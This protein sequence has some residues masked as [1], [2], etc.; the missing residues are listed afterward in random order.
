M[1]PARSGH[2]SRPP[3]FW[4]AHGH[5]PPLVLING[6][7]ASGRAWPRAWLR[8]LERRFRVVTFDNRG[9]GFARYADTP[10]SIADLA[11]DAVK[12]MDA[13]DSPVAALFG[14]SM[15][16]MIA[17]ELALRHPERVTRL[18]LAASRPPNP[19]FRPPSLQSTLMMVRP[20]LP[21]ESLS[22]Y[23]EKLWSHSAAP[24]FAETHPEAIA[25][26]V[27]QSLE[28]PTGR[29]MLIAQARAMTAWGHSD[30]LAEIDTPTLVVH[31]ALDPLSPVANGRAVAEL[32]PG[33]PDV[34][35]PD[36]GH[37]IP[38]E[39]PAAALELIDEHL[40]GAPAQA[41]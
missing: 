32:I 7:A 18:I 2:R 5:G 17:Q 35:L 37:L 6:F 39:A 16:G 23:F 34:E 22:R 25:E 4:Q 15:G 11:D 31:G 12:V 36:V 20:P 14:I 9:S 26:L 40:L 27:A 30:R 33:A 38:Q 3:G 28:R 19:A 10:F 1:S 21:G 24:G 41:A 29:A 8:S 13:A